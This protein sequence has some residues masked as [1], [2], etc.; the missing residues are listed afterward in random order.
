L[1]EGVNQ[2]VQSPVSV[3]VTCSLLELVYFKV[4]SENLSHHTCLL[5]D[6]IFHVDADSIVVEA[7]GFNNEAV[8]AFPVTLPVKLP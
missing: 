2:I 6:G 5:P 8:L 1:V 4:V 3:I 7:I